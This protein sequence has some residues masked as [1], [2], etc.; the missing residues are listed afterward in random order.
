MASRPMNVK[1]IVPAAAVMP[2]MPLGAKSAKLS[3]VEARERDR[4]EHQQ[5]RELDDDHRGV[6]LG[7]L[8]RTADEQERAHRDQDQ[9][10][11]VDEARLGI[12]RGGGQRG[13]D[14]PA[15]QVV[16]QLVQVAAPPDRHGRRRDPVLQQQAGRDAHRDHLAERRVGVG[17]RRPGDGDRGRHLGVRQRGQ[18]CRETGQHERDDHGGAGVGHRLVHDE[19]DARA[20]G[21][22]DAEHHQRERAEGPFEALARLRRHGGDRLLAPQLRPQGRLRDR[23]GRASLEGVCRQPP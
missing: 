22:A 18:A 4:D 19:E 2:A 13:R 23:H 15:E 5:D 9:R 20:D 1:K 7:G 16:Q 12:P 10:G 6:D 14:L 3:D 17:V 21:R 8:G 11:Q